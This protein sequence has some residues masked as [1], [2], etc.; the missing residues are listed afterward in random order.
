MSQDIAA[1]RGFIC[2]DLHGD[3]IP[4]VLAS[5]AAQEQK[6]GKDLS[7][8]LVI[9]DPGH[10]SSAVG[11]NLIDCQES[12]SPAVQISEMVN[13]LKVRWSLDH[14][15]ARTEELLRNSLWAL[16]EN[17]LT[18]LELSPFLT[19]AAYRSS[20]LAKVTNRE[21][22]SF[23]EER[24]DRAS[25]AMQSVMR[26]AVLNKMTTFT[27]D[28]TIRHIVGQQQSSFSVQS[29]LDQRFWILLNLRKGL[30]GD[31]ALTFAGLFL[32]KFKNAIFGRGNRILF[33]LYADE[34]PNLVAADS[35]FESLLSESRKFAISI[36]TANQFLNQ[37]SPAMK[38]ALFSVGTHLCFQ[39]SAEDAPLMTKM[40]DG[41]QQL[42]RRLRTLEHRHFVGRFGELTQEIF[43]PNIRR[44]AT[45]PSNLVGRS[46]RRFAKT[47][48]QIEDE[49]NARRTKSTN[50][51]HLEDWD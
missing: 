42:I 37:F 13:L 11:L 31:N 51:N 5:L 7:G 17:R 33:T 38:S 16:C 22:K 36:V 19:S 10:P 41:E 29:A 39:L 26:E 48:V 44:P 9:I 23:F 25:E 28:S 20:L 46:L 18:L 21:V 34:L 30:L 3:L 32:T 24:Y 2:I 50:Q 47:R 40:L 43:V 6:G 1:G 45:D 27:V 14:F 49:I 12:A 15:G 8:R 35:T 4:F